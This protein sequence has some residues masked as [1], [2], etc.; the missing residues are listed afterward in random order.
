MTAMEI[1]PSRN[2]RGAFGILTSPAELASMAG[3]IL[4][5]TTVGWGLNVLFGIRPPE[6]GGLTWF[7]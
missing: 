6:G 1:P 7:R 3:A 5:I 2:R 4:L